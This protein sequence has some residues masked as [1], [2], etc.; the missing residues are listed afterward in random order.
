[1]IRKWLRKLFWSAARPPAL[2]FTFTQKQKYQS[3]DASPHS[4]SLILGIVRKS[5]ICG[6]TDA[7]GQ[8]VPITTLERPSVLTPVALLLHS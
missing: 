7:P 4:K 1:M 6:K 5:A 8:V 3:G 2:V